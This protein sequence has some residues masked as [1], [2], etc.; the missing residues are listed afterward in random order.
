MEDPIPMVEGKSMQIN[1]LLRMKLM[2][3]MSVEVTCVFSA[4]EP[5][6]GHAALVP[7]QF[8]YSGI[9]VLS[10]ILALVRRAIVAIRAH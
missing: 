2:A 4:G 5:T 1:N 8:C 6:M 3:L 7:Q 9:F 10:K